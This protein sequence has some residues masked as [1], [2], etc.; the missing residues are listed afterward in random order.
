ME[1][2]DLVDR[3]PSIM[4]TGSSASHHVTS[5]LAHLGRLKVETVN[6]RGV[7]SGPEKE[8]EIPP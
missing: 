2:G 1:T 4:E 7:P 8:Q 6:H 5:K 3:E